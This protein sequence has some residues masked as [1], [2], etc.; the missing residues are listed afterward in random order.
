MGNNFLFCFVLGIIPPPKLIFLRYFKSDLIENKNEYSEIAS[1]WT[2]V[3][4]YWNNQQRVNTHTEESICNLC[5]SRQEVLRATGRRPRAQDAPAGCVLERDKMLRSEN[6]AHSRD[7]HRRVHKAHNRC[8]DKENMAN[9]RNQRG[10]IV[11]LA[12]SGMTW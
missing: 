2:L 10:E 4:S 8:T 1:N 3:H 5:G 11:P 12:T 6:L 7:H 9:R